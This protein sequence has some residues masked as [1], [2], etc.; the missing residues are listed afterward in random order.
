[1]S[2]SHLNPDSPNAAATVAP[3]TMRL[4]LERAGYCFV[5]RE[6]GWHECLVSAERERWIGRG[7]TADD[8]LSDAFNQLL[9]SNLARFLLTQTVLSAQPLVGL[10]PAPTHQVLPPHTSAFAPSTFAPAQHAPPREPTRLPEAA[11]VSH[12]AHAWTTQFTAPTQ[13]AHAA[14]SATGADPTLLSDSLSPVPPGSLPPGL[15][16]VIPIAGALVSS[17]NPNLGAVI[18]GRIVGPTVPHRPLAEG[19]VSTQPRLKTSAAPPAPAVSSR[20]TDEDIAE[21]EVLDDRLKALLPDLAGFSRDLQ[22]LGFI[23]FIARARH[24]GFRTADARVDQLVR[25]IAGRLGELAQQFWP[26]SVRALQIRATP[27]QAGADMGLPEGGKLHDWAEAAE[28]AERLV[29]E[30]RATLEDERLDEAGWADYD[31]CFP[32]PNDPE[33]R[34]EMVRNAMEKLFGKLDHP[35]STEADRELQTAGDKHVGELV[36]WA[37]ELRWLRPHVED[38]VRW[39]QAIGRLRWA[40]TRLPRD[41]RM[42]LETALDE[43]HRPHKIW[44]AELGE[45]PVA[46]QKKKLR[47]ALLQKKPEGDK[48]TPEAVSD[49]LAEAFE[50]G[51]A[52]TTSEIA[53][54]IPD[55]NATVLAL[56]TDEAPDR[57]RKYRRR[58]KLLQDEVDRRERGVTNPTE[59]TDEPIELVLG[60][61]HDEG[62]LA[63]RRLLE[64]VREKV[65]GKN[66]L[67]VSNRADPLLKEKLE[68][69]LGIDIEWAEIDPR[70]LQA[71]I[72]SVRQ[73]TFDM[74]LSATGFQG[75]SVDATLGR[76]TKACGLPYVRVNR[77]RL[78]TCVRAIARQFGLLEAA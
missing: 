65:S 36:R 17:T 2:R 59:A 75:H 21:L 30:R 69:E 78:T 31:R 18:T 42:Q 62:D 8:A 41:H 77:G 76:E 44:A 56:P 46:K 3:Q 63:F 53:E 49:W 24:I 45:D 37:R 16:A 25:R 34:L 1:M 12:A 22:R 13:Q 14:P 9:P 26:G 48:A 64:R 19:A 38:R 73:R 54:R 4:L 32:G 52:F 47:K 35:S 71:R 68:R 60:L 15:A 6:A 51:D 27:L 57:D 39:G 20:R 23:A 43:Q 50:L 70:R 66:A 10:T 67:F 5:L 28:A 74:V 55:W 7:V 72:E 61:D 40:S 33:A 11:P 58:L 29:E